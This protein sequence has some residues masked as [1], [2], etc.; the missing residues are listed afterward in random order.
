MWEWFMR[1]QMSSITELTNYR[2]L[3]WFSHLFGTHQLSKF[4]VTLQSLAM[5]HWPGSR[6]SIHWLAWPGYE[7]TIRRCPVGEDRWFRMSGRYL[8]I[9]QLRKKS[10]RF[11]R[12]DIMEEVK[13][14]QQ[15]TA[16]HKEPHLYGIHLVEHGLDEQPRARALGD[17]VDP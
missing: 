7:S 3:Y 16:R 2:S 4:F 11:T 8:V 1:W 14:K 17:S 12:C 13:T 10:I 15:A 5:C 6:S 9:W